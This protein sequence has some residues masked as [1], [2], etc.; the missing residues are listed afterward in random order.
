MKDEVY[1]CTLCCSVGGQHCYRNTKHIYVRGPSPASI[2]RS[3]TL[4]QSDPESEAGAEPIQSD[5]GSEAGAELFQSDP[6]SKGGAEPIQSDPG[7][8][9]GAEPIQ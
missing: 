2:R 7:S 5:P 4:I 6:G 1:I 8:E 9:A 3:S